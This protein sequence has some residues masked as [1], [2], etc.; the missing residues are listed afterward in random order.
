MFFR[1]WWC[2]AL[3][4]MVARVQCWLVIWYASRTIPPTRL[5]KPSDACAL[6]LWRPKNKKRSSHSLPNLSSKRCNSWILKYKESLETKRVI[7]A[8]LS[9]TDTLSS[10]TYAMKR[11]LKWMP[12][13]TH[14]VENIINTLTNI[15][16]V[17]KD[18]VS[19]NQVWLNFADKGIHL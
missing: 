15:Y 1:A 12:L 11:S 4:G 9:D 14:F 5:L 3:V 7:V 18:V 17:S 16:G 2:I 6:V 19:L 8:A 10:L 13:S